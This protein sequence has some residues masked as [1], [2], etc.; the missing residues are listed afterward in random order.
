MNTILKKTTLNLS[1]LSLIAT[2]SFG[3]NI[4]YNI[5]INQKDIKVKKSV[6]NDASF[7]QQ[8]KTKVVIEP[9]S[10]YN[11]LYPVKKQEIA[12]QYN[13]LNNI[14]RF[15]SLNATIENLAQRLINSSRVKESYLEDIAITTFVDL[16]K[17]TKT[18]HFGRNISES[19]LDELFTR[20]FNVSEFRGQDNLS[21]NKN[22][23]YYLTRDIKL[24]NKPVSNK[25]ILVGTYSKFEDSI[26]ISARIINN[27]SGRVV[28]SARSYYN[29]DD[30]KLLDS[31]PK[32]RI[33]NI[34]SHDNYLVKNI[35]KNPSK[36][37]KD[38]VNKNILKTSQFK[39]PEMIR[40]RR[41]TRNTISLIN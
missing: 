6:K 9:S 36:Y 3:Q 38:I 40:R 5:N 31:C 32:K 13:K 1:L 22:G 18:S 7:N 27:S 30:C 34:V 20:G 24:L 12:N 28:A 2:L 33:I 35:V 17:F 16:H 19:L 4:T 37:Y 14:N 29:T 41:V 15:N 11:T 26:L 10:K 23:E 21:I 25:Y 8:D 39:K